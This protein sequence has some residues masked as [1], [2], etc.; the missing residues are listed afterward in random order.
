MA[1]A[2]MPIGWYIFKWTGE[3]FAKHVVDFGPMGAA[4]GLGIHFA[5]ADLNGNGKLDVVAPSPTSP[6]PL[7]SGVTSS[8][9]L[10][11]FIPTVSALFVR[12]MGR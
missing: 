7:A 6:P 3:C 11:T 5:V 10:K 2:K 1:E 4:Q 12:G 8:I 9:I